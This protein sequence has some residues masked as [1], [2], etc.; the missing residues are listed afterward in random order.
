MLP[1]S[2]HFWLLF[3]TSNTLLT[4]PAPLWPLPAFPNLGPSPKP[5]RPLPLL[6]PPP[7]ALPHI[8]RY[9]AIKASC[10]PQGSAHPQLQMV[11]TI[12][13]LLSTPSPTVLLTS[14][15]HS[16]LS[17]VS[18]LSLISWLFNLLTL[19]LDYHCHPSCACAWLGPQRLPPWSC[20]A[21][22]LPHAD[23]CT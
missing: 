23:I 16:L 14:L 6:S 12:S 22:T 9:G 19:P 17:N 1:V 10:L 5:W 20:R 2:C 4:F 15:H 21:L 18:S 7:P 3:T 8:S 13:H 11:S